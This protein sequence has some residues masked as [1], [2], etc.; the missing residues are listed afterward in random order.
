MEAKR[1]TLFEKWRFSGERS[2]DGG[3]TNDVL[4]DVVFVN[5]TTQLFV[6]V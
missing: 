4:G 5:I 3:L 6:R 2:V 1:N